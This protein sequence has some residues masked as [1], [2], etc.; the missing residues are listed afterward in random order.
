MKIQ[1]LHL[2]IAVALLLPPAPFSAAFQ[3]TL[4]SMRRNASAS[5]LGAACVWQ[6]WVDFARAAIGVYLLTQRAVLTDSRQPGAELQGLAIQSG[7]LGIVLLTQTVRMFR[8][9]QFLAPVFYL[10][11]ITLMMG[12]N[13]FGGDYYQGLFAVV[14]GW[15]FAIGG[16][17]LSYQLPTMAVALG[18]AGSI[19]G[20]GVPLMLNCAF[21]LIPFF[22]AAL[23]QRRLLFVTQAVVPA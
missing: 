7:I 10:C 14:V 1:W 3:K 9:V 6:N 4:L 5:A 17:N 13:L 20:Y 15:F 22:L 21:I 23:F 2:L 18:A 11:G 19:L 16:K 8:T 12:G